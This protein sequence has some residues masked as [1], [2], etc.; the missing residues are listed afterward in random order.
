MERVLSFHH[1]VLEQLH[2]HIE[3]CETAQMLTDPCGST[4]DRKAMGSI[5]IF[6]MILRNGEQLLE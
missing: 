4:G 3:S 6:G 1:V 5:A 2:I